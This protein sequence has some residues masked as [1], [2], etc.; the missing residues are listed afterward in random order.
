M[1]TLYSLW[2]DDGAKNIQ[3]IFVSGDRNQDGF[4]SLMEDVSWVALPFGADK[5]KI[6]K[7]VPPKGYPTAGVISG[8]KGVV[9]TPDCSGK[10]DHE[11]F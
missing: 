2:N 3:V 5:S 8:V 9:I 7:E 6:E 11:N 1:K 10:V 4:N